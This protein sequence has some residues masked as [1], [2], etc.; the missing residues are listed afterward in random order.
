MGSSAAATAYGILLQYGLGGPASAR[1]AAVWYNRAAADGNHAGAQRA[2][3]AYAVGWGVNRDTGKA[4]RLLS[5]LEP[6]ARAKQ[7]I[8]ISQVMLKPSQFEPDLAEDWLERALALQTRSTS[9]AVLLY[10][11]IRSGD[12]ERSAA[13]REWLRARAQKGDLKAANRLADRL[14]TAKDQA[15]HEEAARW[16]LTAAEKGDVRARERL[17]MLLA[18]SEAGG[19][20]ASVRTYVEAQAKAGSNAARSTLA[21]A[22]AYAPSPAAT[23]KTASDGYLEEVAR[24]GNS[25]A[26]Y[27]LGMLFLNEEGDAHRLALAKAY[28]SLAAA[29][30][31]PMA[32]SAVSHL[33]TMPAAK[34]Q[35]LIDRE[36]KTVTD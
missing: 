6:E 26:Q 35:A 21:E 1:E 11:Q 27:K 14:L 23:P 9:K 8:A 36:P 15:S 4:R 24:S 2:A 22:F 32:K 7:M 13:V 3:L 20:P 30:G 33:G 34:A 16:F 28:L 19:T 29:K 18:A 5:T 10:E 12:D 25:E 17:A 31:N